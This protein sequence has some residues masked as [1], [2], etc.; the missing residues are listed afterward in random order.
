M[1]LT[2]NI[3]MDNTAFEDPEEIKMILGAIGLMV[4]AG[5][6]GGNIKDSSREIVGTWEIIIAHTGRGGR[7]YAIH[8]RRTNQYCEHDYFAAWR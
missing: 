2:I 3:N 1:K 5:Q 8:K 6:I 4:A 7:R